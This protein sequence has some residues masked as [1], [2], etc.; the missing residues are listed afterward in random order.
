MLGVDGPPER[1]HGE[2]R[3][4]AEQRARQVI[5]AIRQVVL[6]PDADDV[7]VFFHSFGLYRKST[8]KQSDCEWKFLLSITLYQPGQGWVKSKPNQLQIAVFP[9]PTLWGASFLEYVFQLEL[10]SGDIVLGDYLRGNKNFP[11]GELGFVTPKIFAH[12]QSGLVAN[13]ERL[14]DRPCR[15]FRRQ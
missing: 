13:P 7:P 9:D 10:G 14:L 4:E 11:V 2:Q 12:T 8:R 3:N 5:D 1:Q 6:D 15:K